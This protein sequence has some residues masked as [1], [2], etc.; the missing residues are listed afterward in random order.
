MGRGSSQV[1]RGTRM[2][3]FLI[4]RTLLAVLTGFAVL[5]MVFLVVRVLPGDPAQVVLGDFASQSALEAMRTRLGLN[6]SLWQQYLEFLASALS[7]NWGVSMV[8]GRPVIEEILKVLPWTIELTVVSLILGLL[9][10]V[11]LSESLVIW[12][13]KDNLDFGSEMTGS[14]NLVPHI[15]EKTRFT[16]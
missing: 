9:A 2:S 1:L 3:A 14:L 7:G 13:W 6:K 15:T 16:K 5:T 8:T 10:G 11:P 4:R 12:A